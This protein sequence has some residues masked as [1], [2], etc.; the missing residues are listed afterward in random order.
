MDCAALVRT[1]DTHARA[2]AKAPARR[3][4]E[5]PCAMTALLVVPLCYTPALSRGA[6]AWRPLDLW[7]IG[8]FLQAPKACA[9][10][11]WALSPGKWR[12]KEPAMPSLRFRSWLNCS[13]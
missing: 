2:I 8:T 13:G 7:R 4:T 1:G 11:P 10:A 3:E 5:K 9:S 6:N 12:L